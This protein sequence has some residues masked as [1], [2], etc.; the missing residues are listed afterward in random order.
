MEITVTNHA[1]KVPIA[2]IQ[3]SGQLDGQTHQ[4]L[5]NAAKSVYS[6]GTKK[7]LLDF[8]NLT[9]ISSAGLVALHSIAM[10]LRGN[11]IPNS[12]AG[13]ASMQSVR[14]SGAEKPEDNLKLLNPHPEV[15]SVLE[16]VGFDRAFEMYTDLQQALDSF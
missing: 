11:T 7:I 2:V 1:G 6:S 9:Y 12:E 5:I 14:V 16:M 8:T 10:M 15:K 3:L 13:W 4:A